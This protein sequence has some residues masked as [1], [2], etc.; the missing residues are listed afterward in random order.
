MRTARRPPRHSRLGGF[1]Y[2]DTPEIIRCGIEL[3]LFTKTVVFRHKGKRPKDKDKNQMNEKPIRIK[4]GLN[5]SY[6]YRG[7][8]IQK[9]NAGRYSIDFM[10]V[11]YFS[12]LKA[13][14]AFAD[15]R[16]VKA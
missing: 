4:H 6:K 8:Y 2:C 3:T 1:L 7:T 16:I 5:I 11:T 13:A 15:V 9:H 14:M 12:T 10:G